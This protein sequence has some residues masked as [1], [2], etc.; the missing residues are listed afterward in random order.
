MWSILAD[1]LTVADM[2]LDQDILAFDFGSTHYLRLTAGEHTFRF[3]AMELDGGERTALQWLPP[4]DTTHDLG[5]PG[6]WDYIPAQYFSTDLTG[7]WSILADNLTVADM[8]L[9]QDIMTFEFGSTHYLR[10]TTEVAGLIA[11][12]E[13]LYTFVPEPTTSV[14]LGLG[15]LALARRRR[16]N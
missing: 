1:N 10:L 9:D 4:W 12:A 16:K 8:L 15:L 14:L 5:N 13:G 3:V 11:V 6:A 7:M 2:L